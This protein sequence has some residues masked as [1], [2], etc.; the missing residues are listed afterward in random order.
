MAA[1]EAEGAERSLLIAWTRH[2]AG[3]LQGALDEAAT[4]LESH[5]DHV[6]LL[7]QAAWITGSLHRGEESMRFAQRLDALSHPSAP[8]FVEDASELLSVSEEVRAA[9]TRAKWVLGLVSA[10]AILIGRWG[11]GSASS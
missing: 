5:P 9:K 7:E 1:D 10:L 4:G 2:H 3:D 11:M 8:A 6:G